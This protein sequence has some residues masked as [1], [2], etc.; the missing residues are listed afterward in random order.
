VSDP[1]RFNCSTQDQQQS[2]VDRTFNFL[3]IV[4]HATHQYHRTTVPFPIAGRV[5]GG[6]KIVYLFC[7]SFEAP[8][9]KK[10]KM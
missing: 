10:I 9:E 1:K 8:P 2:L 5:V 4:G 3:R 6:F 7:D